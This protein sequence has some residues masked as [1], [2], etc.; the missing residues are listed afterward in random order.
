[1]RLKNAG[2]LLYLQKLSVMDRE[3]RDTEL[4]LVLRNAGT[5]LTN[6]E[7]KHSEDVKNKVSWQKLAPVRM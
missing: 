7:V 5:S 2:T 6:P 4:L 1:M 3:W